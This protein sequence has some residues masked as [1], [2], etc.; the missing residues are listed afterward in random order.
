[1]LSGGLESNS[2]AAL[3]APAETPQRRQQTPHRRQCIYI[4][5]YIV[6]NKKDIKET[7]DYIEETTDTPKETAHTPQ[8]LRRLV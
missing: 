3:N 2:N 4:Y 7:E 8:P 6:L 1:M 5:I